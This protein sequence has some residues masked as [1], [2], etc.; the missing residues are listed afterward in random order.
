MPL[1]N[2][3]HLTAYLYWLGHNSFIYCLSAWPAEGCG[4]LQPIPAATGW[5]AG[6]ALDRS[7]VH[8]STDISKQPTLDAHIHTYSQC[9]IWSI[10]KKKKEPF[11]LSGA[12]T[13]RCTTMLPWLGHDSGITSNKDMVCEPLITCK[14]SST[15]PLCNRKWLP[16]TSASICSCA[17]FALN[18]ASQTPT[19]DL[20]SRN[21]HTWFWSP[22][23]KPTE[24]G[25][26]A[27]NKKVSV[28]QTEGQWAKLSRCSGRFR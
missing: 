11:L 9:R 13:H 10:K 7:P 19:K 17:L 15:N 1:E 8:G 28:P 4:E 26:W 23:L 12:G 20:M 5:Q 25:G 24:G 27:S 6:I 16:F 3:N 14:M 18:G 22:Y 2:C 21:H